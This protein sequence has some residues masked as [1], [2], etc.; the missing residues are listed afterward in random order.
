ML[1]LNRRQLDRNFNPLRHVTAVQTGIPNGGWLKTIR[2]A[3]GMTLEQVATR[4]NVTPQS[5]VK[6]ETSEV[7]GTISLNTMHHIAESMECEVI[8]FI[9]PRANLEK[10]VDIQVQKKAQAMMRVISHSMT[11]ENQEPTPEAMMEQLEDL[12]EQLRHDI[13]TKKN[14]SYIW[15]I[16]E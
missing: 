9:L 15:N 5:I 2:N 4:A 11:L 3:L 14:I 1:N 16:P 8:Y 12:I 13:K 6:S 7:Q 10:M